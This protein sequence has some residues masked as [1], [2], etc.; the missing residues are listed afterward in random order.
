MFSITTDFNL[1][2]LQDWV[3]SDVDAWID[4]LANYWRLRG[5]ELV[6]K[7][8]AKTRDDGGFGNITWNLRGS[9]GM[10]IVVREK[11]LETYFPPISKGAHGDTVGRAMAESLAIY[12]KGNEGVS[13]V[14]VAGE[15]YASIVQNIHGRDVIKHVIGDNLEQALKGIM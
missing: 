5:R 6:D 3:N 12:G 11:I 10:C 7:A 1:Q 2:D 14:F 9:I 15:N 13:M 8:R 4:D